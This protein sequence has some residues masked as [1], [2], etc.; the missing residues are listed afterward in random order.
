VSNPAGKKVRQALGDLWGTGR[1]HVWQPKSYRKPAQR[2]FSCYYRTESKVKRVSKV[3]N[4]VFLSFT[5]TLLGHY[6]AGHSA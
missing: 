1:Y 3:D 5:N 2:G 4:S 6:R